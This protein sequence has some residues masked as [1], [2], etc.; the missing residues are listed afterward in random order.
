MIELLLAS[1]LTFAETLI[2]ASFLTVELY[3]SESTYD[4]VVEVDP[5]YSL[6]KTKHPRSIIIATT[7]LLYKELQ[8]ETERTTPESNQVLHEKM[9]IKAK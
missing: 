1:H 4:V 6:L 7:I 9:N 5:K 2:P 3:V 8:E